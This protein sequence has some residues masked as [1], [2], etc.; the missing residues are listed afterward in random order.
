MGRA[1]REAGQGSDIAH[2]DMRADITKTVRN[3]AA[4][5]YLQAD[6]TMRARGQT[7]PGRR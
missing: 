7:P 1:E 6:T 2:I 5:S 3:D 4:R